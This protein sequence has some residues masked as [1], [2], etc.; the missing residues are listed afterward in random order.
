MIWWLVHNTLSAATLAILATLVCRCRP[1]HPALRHALWLVVLA[2]LVAPPLPVWSFAWPASWP[3]P[4]TWARQV[5]EETKLAA[6]G[7]TEPEQFVAS[8]AAERSSLAEDRMPGDPE[9]F[10]VLGAA[11]VVSKAYDV[12]PTSTI[13][14][15]A[16][17]DSAQ[18]RW[19]N[20]LTWS[21]WNGLIL[22]VW[23]AA[24]TGMLA[25][26][27]YRWRRFQTL[28]D[29]AAAAPDWLQA[30]VREIADELRIDAPE[31]CV[32]GVR[33][34]PLVWVLGRVRLLWPESMLDGFS[35]ES[36]RT[37][38]AHELA[39]LARRDHWVA[40]CEVAA[41]V[42]W[43]WHPLFWFVRAM[44]HDAAEQ[45]CDAR[46]TQLLPSARRAY[47]QALV[48]VCELL[49]QAVT[50]GP[51]LGIGSQ[52]RRAFERR[53]T[54]IMREK[55]ASRLSLGAVTGVGLLALVVLPGF[56]PA[57]DNPPAAGAAPA[58]AV[59]DLFMAKAPPATAEAPTALPAPLPPDIPGAPEP[60]KALAFDSAPPTPASQPAKATEPAAQAIGVQPLRPGFPGPAQNPV[61]L[62]GG[63][64]AYL[65]TPDPSETGAD[66]VVMLTR[67]KYR[68]P[69][70]LAQ[71]FA[72]Y[73]NSTLG[74]VVQAT[75]EMVQSNQDPFAGQPNDDPS[76]IVVT[77]DAETQRIVGHFIGLLRT[78][79][80]LQ[81]GM[82]MGMMSAG[83]TGAG[84][85]PGMPGENPA[86]DRFSDATI[87]PVGPPAGGNT[88]GP[89]GVE[90]T[91][92]YRSGDAATPPL[93]AD[94]EAAP[95]EPARN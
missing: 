21:D 65:P 24:G 35:A 37:I 14:N 49:A 82:E 32:I 33:C 50:P 27:L 19:T 4:G 28:L 61:G 34:T 52:T 70:P 31:V 72:N 62:P 69:G 39:H 81:S 66:E 60:A 68:L 3:E 53:L 10:V 45:A 41:A 86:M 8:V 80:K 76:R 5:W 87:D 36:R 56:T 1:A 89:P 92:P 44:L 78:R 9:S 46:V 84:S 12:K 2:K 77:T 95:F 26:Q 23:L 48:E 91:A 74:D 57:Q 83:M 90:F 42:F 88:G 25:Y 59:D 93:P 13:T 6:S 17:L 11:D 67:A 71:S 43:W 15:A 54:M 18:R 51:A 85:Y 94:G 75:V 55:V 38:I 58:I 73:L 47:A 20:Y 30:E 29:T 63:A 7:A 40:R 22:R 64:G 16:S 79:G